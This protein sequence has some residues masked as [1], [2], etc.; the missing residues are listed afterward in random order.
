MNKLQVFNNEEFGEIRTIE[1]SRC[2]NYVGF[3]YALELDDIVKIGSTAHPHKRLVA[4][5]RQLEVYGNTRLGR[6]ALSQEHTNYR[7]NEKILHDYFREFR[8]GNTELFD[9]PLQR[10]VE[11]SRGL[12]FLDESKAIK[13]ESERVCDFFKEI[14]LGVSK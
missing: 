8:R 12:A 5:R 9:I 13:Q 2:S 14:L 6:V 10:V 7:E 4:L 11:V 1:E 3:V